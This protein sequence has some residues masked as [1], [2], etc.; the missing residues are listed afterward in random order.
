MTSHIKLDRHTILDYALSGLRAE[1]AG[2]YENLT[3]KEH[4]AYEK[5]I[6]ELRRRIKLSNQG[7]KRSLKS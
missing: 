1:Y 7:I 6:A 4:E 3:D 2:N 5:A